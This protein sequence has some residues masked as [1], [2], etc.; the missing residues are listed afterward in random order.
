MP[1]TKKQN[2]YNYLMK[3]IG[4]GIPNMPNMK[5][6]PPFYIA[7]TSGFYRP[8]MT[9]LGFIPTIFRKTVKSV[10]QTNYGVPISLASGRYV[11]NQVQ[12]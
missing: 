1:I 9:G 12:N 11:N 10:V 4:I 7:Q 8:A 6:G 3:G 2:V 5:M